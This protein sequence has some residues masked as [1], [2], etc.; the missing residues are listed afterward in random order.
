MPEEI[1]SW[2]SV[3]DFILAC[4]R[5]EGIPMFKTKFAGQRFL[6]N[7]VLAICW[8]GRDGV[9]SVFFTDVPEEDIKLLEEGIGDWRRLLNKYATKEEILEAESYGIYLKG[10]KL[11]RV[12]K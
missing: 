11:P 8:G 6:G 12:V 7:G 9:G 10:H 5:D 2:K 4:R 3:K 1:L